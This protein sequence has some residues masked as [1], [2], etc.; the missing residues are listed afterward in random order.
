MVRDGHAT[1]VHCIQGRP[2]QGLHIGPAFRRQGAEPRGFPRAGRPPQDDRDVSGY[3]GID[4]LGWRHF[5]PSIASIAALPTTASVAYE[6][7]NVAWK[8][9]S[10][11]SI[12]EDVLIFFRS[13][14]ASGHGW[15]TFSSHRAGERIYES[16]DTSVTWPAKIHPGAT[17]HMIFAPGFIIADFILLPSNFA[18]SAAFAGKQR[19]KIKPFFEMSPSRIRFFRQSR[20]CGK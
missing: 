5:T 16:S 13:L 15:E 1:H 2:Y 3:G 8:N 9:A 6:A 18:I 4:D 7:H 19:R 17:P 10:C 12:A 14:A 11:L 20:G